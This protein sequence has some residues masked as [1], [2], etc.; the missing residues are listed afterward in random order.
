MNEAFLSHIW[1]N[2]LFNQENLTCCS[3]Q[4]LEILKCGHLNVDAGPDF[5][6]AKIKINDTIWAG[7]VELHIAA[8]EWY[9]HLHHKDPAYDR[10]IL[11]VVYENDQPVIDKQGNAVPT[12][13]LKGRIQHRHLTNYQKLLGAESWIPCQ[14]HLPPK[15]SLIF[16][17]TLDRALADRMLEKSRAIASA[18]AMHQN[19]WEEVFYQKLMRAMGLRVNADAMESLASRIPLKLL[20]KNAAKIIDLESLLFG[21][22]GFLN[23]DYE[24]DYFIRLKR[25]HEHFTSKYNLESMNYTRWKFMRMRPVSF[26]TI[27]IAQMAALL[28]KSKHLFA[29]ILTAHNIKELRDYF[30]IAASSYWTDHYTFKKQSKVM[31]KFLGKS[32]IDGI[33]I[34]TIV[35]FLFHYSEYT[36]DHQHQ[37]KAISFLEALPAENNKVIRQWKD[38]GM[39]AENAFD[40]QSLLQLKKHQCDELGC[41]ACPIGQAIVSS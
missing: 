32:T 30:E 31:P 25:K 1:S 21:L 34:N 37:Q 20:R 23:D 9:L 15:S 28:F 3:G 19:D 41:L 17:N 4:S 6:N 13:E 10:V 24:D 11:H 40:S 27:R 8:A 7:N 5:F 2:K 14:N 29:S 39:L 16:R 33:I 18:L 36:G 12:L 22:G 26:P 35:P 38:L